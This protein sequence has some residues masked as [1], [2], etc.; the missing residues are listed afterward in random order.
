MAGGGGPAATNSQLLPA[1][2]THWLSKNEVF[3]FIKN[4]TNV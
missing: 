3:S 2:V 1:T 4:N